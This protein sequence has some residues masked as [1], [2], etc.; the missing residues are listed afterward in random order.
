VS[1][2]Y[3]F[4]PEEKTINFYSQDKFMSSTGCVVVVRFSEHEGSPLAC[5]CVMDL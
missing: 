4:V 5:M 3:L 1:R 2:S